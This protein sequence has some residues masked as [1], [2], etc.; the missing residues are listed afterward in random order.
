MTFRITYNFDDFD[1]DR[2][3]TEIQNSY[4]GG[5][6]SADQIVRSFQ[7]SSFTGLFDCGQPVGF[8]R[9]FSDRVFSTYVNDLFVYEDCRGNGH[10]HRLLKALFA[11]PELLEIRHRMLAT[12]DAHA[13][14]EKHGFEMVAAGHFMGMTRSQ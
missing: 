5:N 9:A 3:V 11:H 4:W 12:K 7:H 2:V 13:L 8:V 10:S 1:Q 6:R 14:Y